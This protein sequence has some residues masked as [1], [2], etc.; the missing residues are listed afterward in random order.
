MLIE[1]AYASAP[2][3][4]VADVGDEEQAGG[5][6]ELRLGGGVRVVGEAVQPLRAMR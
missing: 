4:L 5:R 3:R 1:E 2:D 6:V